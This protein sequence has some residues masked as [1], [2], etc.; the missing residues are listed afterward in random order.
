MIRA[1][2]ERRARLLAYCEAWQHRIT[3][4]QQQFNVLHH[5]QASRRR[6]QR[7]RQT[8]MRRQAL[9]V[10][11][12]VAAEKRAKRLQGRRR[13]A[14]TRALAEAQLQPEFR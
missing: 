1:L 9:E 6:A 4:H 8:Q 2:Q 14:A 10:A 13:P 3:V 5:A 7:T 11:R 12:V